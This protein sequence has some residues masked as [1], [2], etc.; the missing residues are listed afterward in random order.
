MRLEGVKTRVRL[1]PHVVLP[2]SAN[3]ITQQR[4]YVIAVCTLPRLNLA[5]KSLGTCLEAHGNAR[6]GNPIRP[7]ARML[8][9]VAAS[10]SWTYYC[11][12]LE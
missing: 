6:L 1:S 5:R 2:R 8:T 9:D 12:G 3:L 4:R 11:E 10:Q 7:C